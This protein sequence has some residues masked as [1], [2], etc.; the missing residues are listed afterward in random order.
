MRPVVSGLLPLGL[1]VR[2]RDEGDRYRLLVAVAE[3]LEADARAG[4]VA[5]DDARKVLGVRNLGL[6][7][8]LDHV[9]GLEPRLR[10][11]TVGDHLADQR[12]MR[13]VHPERLRER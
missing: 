2:D 13:M 4:R 3:D 5:R 8:L 7:D 1:I 11:R 12:A 9:A 6:I 10:P